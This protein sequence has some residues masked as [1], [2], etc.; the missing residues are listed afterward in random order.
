MRV[1]VREREPVKR[2][3]RVRELKLRNG[4]V[5]AVFILRVLIFF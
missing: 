1:R 3:I 2:V 5:R 4:K